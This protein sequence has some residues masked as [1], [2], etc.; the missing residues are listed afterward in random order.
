MAD[1]TTR[2]PGE[3]TL[4]ELRAERSRLQDE[5]D[6]VSYVRRAAQSRLD[7]VRAARERRRDG[8]APDPTT[9]DMSGE[10]RQVLAQHLTAGPSARP[11]RTGRDDVADGPLVDE[12]D[13]LCAEGG[14]SRVSSP[15]APL[16]DDELAALELALSGFERRISD[17]RRARFDRI[18]ALGTELVRRYRSGEADVDSLLVD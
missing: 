7:L 5:D 3:L 11:P 17:D 16:D 10:L 4:D 2:G 8:V 15:T 14:F 1:V 18:D 6:R 13:R 9:A 12:L